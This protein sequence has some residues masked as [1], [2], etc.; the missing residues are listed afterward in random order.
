MAAVVSSKR[1]ERGLEGTQRR[2]T[3]RSLTARTRLG[4]LQ[5]ARAPGAEDDAANG[6]G[7]KGR[8]HVD[9]EERPRIGLEG[10]VDSY[11]GEGRKKEGE[12]AD[13][14]DLQSGQGMRDVQLHEQPGQGVIDQDG[15]DD[16]DEIRKDVM[17]LLDVRHGAGV[18]VQPSFAKE[19]IPAEPDGEMDKG[20]DADG[21]MMDSVVQGR[22]MILAGGSSMASG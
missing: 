21:E 19:R 7:E 4:D 8:A 5:L 15:G 10:G 22:R 14:R 11:T 20:K 1:P 18:E 6:E 3:L 12:P 13:E 16:A 2:Q 9:K 17:R